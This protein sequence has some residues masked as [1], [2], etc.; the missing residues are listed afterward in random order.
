MEADDYHFKLKISVLGDKGVGKS[1][2]IDGK[3]LNLQ[4]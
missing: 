1:A 2:I 4:L 3:I